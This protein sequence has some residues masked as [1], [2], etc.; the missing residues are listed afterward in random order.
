[1]YYKKSFAQ[2]FGTKKPLVKCWWNCHLIDVVEGVIGA[3]VVVVEVRAVERVFASR[4]VPVIGLAL[5]TSNQ[6]AN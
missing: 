5:E 3:H 6:Q 2:N 1:M 4:V